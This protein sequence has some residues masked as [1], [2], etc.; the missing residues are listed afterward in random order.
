MGNVQTADILQ[1][2]NEKFQKHLA[3]MNKRGLKGKDQPFTC[4]LYESH[5][6]YSEVGKFFIQ[7]KMF[8]KQPTQEDFIRHA[9]NFKTIFESINTTQYPYFII[10]KFKKEDEVLILSRQYIHM[11]LKDKLQSGT[12]M[13]DHQKAF[14]AVQLIMAVIFLH[15]IG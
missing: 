8:I 13:S 1:R 2:Q 10:P 6:F 7:E 11:T 5:I 9:R 15:E 3:M 14:I 4:Q 12:P